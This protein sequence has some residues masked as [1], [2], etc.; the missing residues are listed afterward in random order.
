MPEEVILPGGAKRDYR[1][2]PLMRI[3]EITGKDP[4]DNTIMNQEYTY[5]KVG[6]ILS[7]STE[8]GN[9]IYSYDNL[10]RLIMADNPGDNDEYYTYD[11][12]GN[13]WLIQRTINTST[14]QIMN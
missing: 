1:Y 9:Y 7:K 11:S 2:D 3:T 12:V 10:R 8:H 5:D 14:M 4:D 6:D 13:D